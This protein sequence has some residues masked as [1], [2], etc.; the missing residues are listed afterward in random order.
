MLSRTDLKT[1]L[2]GGNVRRI[3]NSDADQSN[4]SKCQKYSHFI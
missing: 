4:P 3:S 2:A 1:D